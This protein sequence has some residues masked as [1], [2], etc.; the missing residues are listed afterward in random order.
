MLAGAAA[1]A[2]P[3]VVTHPLDTCKA[4]IQV[5]TQSAS[6][7]LRTGLAAELAR[8]AR[9]EGVRALYRGFPTAFWGAAPAGCLYFGAYEASKK[10]LSPGGAL[11]GVLGDSSTSV[12]LLSGLLAEAASC[13]LWVP[14]DVVKERLQVQSA[15]YGCAD[16][17]AESSAESAAARS[18]MLYR[19]NVDAFKSILSTEGVRGLY[20]GYGATLLSFG[21]FSAIFFALNEQFK[22][23]WMAR[24]GVVAAESLAHPTLAFATSGA[25]AGSIA[26]FATNPMDMVKL[27]LQ[28]QR[29]ASA[30]AATDAA[31]PSAFNYR[32]LFHGMAEI[33]RHEGP[34]ALFKG[35][36]A[37]VAFQAPTTT[38]AITSFETLRLH[39]ARVV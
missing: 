26:A 31:G 7:G 2:L 13:V 32:G 15:L 35:A 30:L 5:R 10:C 9:G 20:R 16:S 37:R 29:S 39:F 14:I 17:G 6:V 11:G 27:R 21:P 12:H 4:R 8:T 1:G 23:A 22:A 3:R 28:V 19:G 25:A 38:I 33:V 18:T 24:E 36:C 34:A